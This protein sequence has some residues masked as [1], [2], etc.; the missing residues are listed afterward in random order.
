[1]CDVGQALGGPTLAVPDRFGG[2]E[3]YYTCQQK[4]W[5]WARGVS[6]PVRL[7]PAA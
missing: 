7:A 5:K 2:R 6:S 3:D 4:S 1:M